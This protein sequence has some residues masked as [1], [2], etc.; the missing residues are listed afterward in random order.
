MAT[1]AN[2]DVLQNKTVLNDRKAAS[3]KRNTRGNTKIT[4]TTEDGNPTTE[5][6]M[7]AGK[8][9]SRKNFPK[10]AE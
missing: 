1:A 8:R 7:P 2:K 5:V 3:N 10:D 6:D 9:G 4:G